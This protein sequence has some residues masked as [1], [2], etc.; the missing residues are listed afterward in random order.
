MDI[1]LSD[2][3]F[4]D[5][6]GMETGLDLSDKKKMFKTVKELSLTKERFE[7][8]EKALEDVE[9]KGYGIV[10]PSSDELTLEEPKL[11]K[12]NGGW[13]VQVCAHADTI[14]MIKTGIRADLCPMVGTEA[15]SEEVVAYL[16]DEFEKDP[17]KI[18]ESNMFGKS[19]YDLVS[20]G[21]NGK[22][23]NIP[24]EAREKLGETLEK[25]INEGA[26]GLLCIL[27]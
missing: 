20:D 19:L 10:M 16:I 14:H 23:S 21:M 18:W 24:D 26:G 5:T 1:P 9:N 27:L 6:L 12:T 2:E 8:I 4:F 11:V 22:L 7:K 13:G 25:I 15:Q 17:E 3:V